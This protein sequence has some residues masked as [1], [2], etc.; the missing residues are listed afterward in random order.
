MPKKI[1]VVCRQFWPEKI[2]I[3]DLCDKLVSYGFK[4]DVLCGQPSNEAGEFQRGYNSFK[5]RRESHNKINVYR[6]IDVKRGYVSNVRIFLNYVTFPLMAKQVTGK[7]ISNQYEAVL[8]YQVSPVMMCGPGLSVAK[9]L[10]IP[11]YICVVDQWP[12]SV[13]LSMDIQS[14]LFRRFLYRL[15]MEYYRKADKLI[16]PSSGIRK[17]F[18]DRL[19]MMDRDLPLITDF[20]DPPFEQNIPDNNLLEKLAGCFNLLV[21]GDF[22]GQLAVK[23]ILKVAGMIR[24]NGARN[25]RFVVTGT[26]E[27]IVQLRDKVMAEGLNDQ[28]YFEGRITTMDISRYIHVTDIITAFVKP[29]KINDLTIPHEI[30]N[31]LAAG[32]P[33]VASLSGLVRELIRS[34]DCGYTTEPD[35]AKGLFNGI[36]KIYRM[37]EEKRLELG[38]NAAAYQQEFFSRD[39]NAELFARILEGENL[40]GSEDSDSSIHQLIEM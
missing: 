2:R 21:M 23:T 28:F 22:D 17:Y 11:A 33:V 3:N 34:A 8:I 39:K 4:V 18:A 31:Y 20:P 24:A 7:L 16:V 32:K 40:E 30:I 38:A 27:K 9:K 10:N 29:E 36:M 37:P 1:L 35:D 15:S 19:G 6:T 14:S 25:I 26:G 5:V 12:Q 13:Y